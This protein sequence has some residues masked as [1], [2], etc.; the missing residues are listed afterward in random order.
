MRPGHVDDF[1]AAFRAR[2]A[3]ASRSGSAISY[4]VYEVM[5][6][7]PGPSFIVITTV[8]HYAGLDTVMASEDRL[9]RAATAEER[10]RIQHFLAQ[11][12]M[13]VETNLYSLDPE[14]SYVSEEVR[15]RDPKFWTAPK[16]P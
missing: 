15:A 4:E 9:M 12:C 2:K 5:S 3:V 1:V 14:L 8:G 11:G 10:S 7:M 6:G 16:S 13:S